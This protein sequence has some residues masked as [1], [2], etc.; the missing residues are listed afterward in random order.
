VNVV[1]EGAF[2]RG[3]DLFNAG[4]HVQAEKEF[5]QAIAIKPSYLPLF[6]NL[7]IKYYVGSED[8]PRAIIAFRFLLQL[9]PEYMVARNN[10]ARAY[11]NFGI[12]EARKENIKDALD[13]FYRALAVDSTPE[14]VAIIKRSLVTA[15]TELAAR[16]KAEG[17][18][19]R[20]VEYMAHACSI[21]PSDGTRRNLGLAYS[22]LGN[23]LLKDNKIGEAIFFFELAEDAGIVF[24]PLYNNHGS[25]LA[26]L[27]E[28]AEAK[29]LLEKALE[30]EPDYEI[31]REN[32]HRLLEGDEDH[33]P[34]VPEIV[35]IESDFDPPPPMQVQE[36]LVAA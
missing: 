36:Y 28:N 26:V 9:D 30:L 21:E 32:L 33:L 10:L 35:D 4:L 19:R 13:L 1:A 8:W 12:Q 20:S 2:K 7:I 31:A 25:A 16:K 5:K 23:S 34:Q 11:L 29:R 22:L 24:P 15:Y 18:L 3:I 27:G 14:T 17:D 6:H